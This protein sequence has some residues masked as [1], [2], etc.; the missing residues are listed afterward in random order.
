[1]ASF[2]NQILAILTTPP[3]IL[4]YNIVV[5]FSVAGAL[6]LAAHSWYVNGFPQSRRTTIGLTLLL[7]CQGCLFVVGGLNLENPVLPA[8]LLPILDRTF[9]AFGLILVIWLWAFPEPLRLA[10]LTSFILGLLIVALSFFSAIWWLDS[11]L[12]TFFNGTLPDIVWGIFDLLLVLLG[13]SILYLRRPDGWITAQIMLVLLFVGF[14]A[15]LWA[16]LQ[17]ND[18][19]GVVRL[20]QMLAYPLLLTLPQRF[21]EQISH[22]PTHGSPSAQ[23]VEG[24]HFTTDLL[25]TFLGLFTGHSLKDNCPAITQILAQSVSADLCLLVSIPQAGDALS[26]LCGYDIIRK[27]SFQEVSLEI[28]QVPLLTE[29]LQRSAPL[30]L[31]ASSTSSDLKRLSQALN[32]SRSGPL[33]AVPFPIVGST[34]TGLVFL[35]P[36][37]NRGWTKQDERSLITLSDAMVDLL[38]RS[39]RVPDLEEQLSQAQEHARGLQRDLEALKTQAAQDQKSIEGLAALVSAQEGG[40]TPKPDTPPT[41]ETSRNAEIQ[42]LE[43]ELRLAL[44]ELAFT[45]NALAGADEKILTLERGITH[46]PVSSDEAQAIASLAQELRQPLSSIISYVDLLLSESV[47]ILGALQRRFLE[48]IKS[49]GERLRVLVEDIVQVAITASS[50]LDLP[51]E[52]L[53]LTALVDEAI[54]SVSHLVQ[55]KGLDL[56]LDLDEPFPPFQADRD[57][58][59]QIILHL[60]QNACYA[61]PKSSEVSLYARMETTGGQSGYLL[62][63]VSD[64]GGGI[65][66]KEIPHLFTRLYRTDNPLIPGVGDRGVGL[67]VVKTLVEAH[68][69]RVWVDTEM[70]YGSTFSVLLPVLV[71]STTSV[72]SKDQ[73]T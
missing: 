12:D 18:F 22:F 27:S 34:L 2:F 39:G 41:R 28:R 64:Q 10:D 62:I 31:P 35:S 14:L 29:A 53:E 69:G 7:A 38:E 24:P 55:E 50:T 6:S 44:E 58:L 16:P 3:G 20:F 5:A 15:H 26:I 45:R 17:E 11:G 36:Y 49:S 68:Q 37:S 42:H 61:T 8:Y 66:S 4:A 32:L 9:T 40:V 23:G 46:Q 25:E 60:I 19:A 59:G 65:P 67:S 43:A 33:L 63:Q 51:P 47:G 48:R 72:P 13:A 30:R 70:G 1:M 54:A 57:A 21:Q 52:P 56:N 73:L 71:F